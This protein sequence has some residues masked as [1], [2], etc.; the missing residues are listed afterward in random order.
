MIRTKDLYSALA[1]KFNVRYPPVGSILLSEIQIDYMSI[2]YKVFGIPN[3]EK[4]FENEINEIKDW[5]NQHGIL[6]DLEDRLYTWALH[7]ISL[8]AITLTLFL[9]LPDKETRTLFA[10]SFPQANK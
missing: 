2:N 9:H 3:I 8:D 1:N 7:M 4:P 10:L 6:H 5:A